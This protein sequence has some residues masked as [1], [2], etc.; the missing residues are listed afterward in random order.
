MRLISCSVCAV[1]MVAESRWC[2][3][4][5]ASKCLLLS[6]VVIAGICLAVRQLLY[7]QHSVGTCGSVRWEQCN[8]IVYEDTED[9]HPGNDC[10][11][12]RPCRDIGKYKLN[13]V[14]ANQSLHLTYTQAFYS[15]LLLGPSLLS[16]FTPAVII[17]HVSSLYTGCPG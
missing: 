7:V 13:A 1:K 16:L 8:E 14:I 11:R 9:T 12:G 17:I 4:D 15:I 5:A 6:N 3:H 2:C 10:G